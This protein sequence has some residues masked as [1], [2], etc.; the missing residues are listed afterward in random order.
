MLVVCGKASGLLNYSAA[1]SRFK[2]IN[3]NKHPSTISDDF[4]T[5]EGTELAR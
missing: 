3:A 4:V 5:V 2:S 1:N